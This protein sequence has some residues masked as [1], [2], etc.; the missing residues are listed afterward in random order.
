MVA[1]TALALAIPLHFEA[2]RSQTGPITGFSA[3]TRRYTLRLS[4]SE[5]TMYFRGGAVY[6]KLPRSHPEGIDELP[7]KSSYYFGSDPAGWRT[8]IPN[9]ARVRYPNVFS[10]VDLVIHGHDQEVEYDWMVAPGADPQSIC[11]SFEG[12]SALSIDNGGDLGLHLNIGGDQATIQQIHSALR[13]MGIVL[14]VRNHADR[15]AS[16]M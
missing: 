12:T 15:C 9:F 7:A 3:A 14:V 5:I 10:G 6:M 16:A 1:L 8:A 4:E 2:I 11:F 13:E